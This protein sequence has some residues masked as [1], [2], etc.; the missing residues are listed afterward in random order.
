MKNLTQIC[1]ILVFGLLSLAL[2]FPSCNKDDNDEQ[3]VKTE[4]L[5]QRAWIMTASTV[6]PGFPTFDNEGNL[7]GTDNDIFA[8]MDDCEIDDTHKFNID[9]TLVTD[10]G[11]TKC[12]SGDPQKLYGTWSFNTDETMLTITEEGET[13]TITLLELTQ[14]VMKLKSTETFEGETYTYT[15]TFS[16]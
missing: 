6:D 7:I 4:L 15:I 14:N 10:E 1:R 11:M 16:H 3:S 9:K 12:D 5:T 13:L 8:M 2:L